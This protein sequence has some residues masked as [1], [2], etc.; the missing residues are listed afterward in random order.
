L[1]SI[2]LIDQRQR[3]AVPNGTGGAVRRR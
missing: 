1:I 3:G 2:T